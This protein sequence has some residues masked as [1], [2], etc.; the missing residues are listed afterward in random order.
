MISMRGVK[1]AD[2]VYDT[3][4]RTRTIGM[5]CETFCGITNRLRAQDGVE[6]MRGSDEHMI[7][8]GPG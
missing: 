5:E 3:D 8:C 2:D 7:P 4:T 6:V 1:C